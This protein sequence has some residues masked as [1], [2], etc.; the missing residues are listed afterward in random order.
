MNADLALVLGLLAASIAMLAIDVVSVLL[1]P[2][3]LPLHPS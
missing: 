2:W 3:L 1:V